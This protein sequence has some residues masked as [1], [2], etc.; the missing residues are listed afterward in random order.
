MPNIKDW[1]KSDVTTFAEL[2]GINV[3]FEGYGFVKEFSINKNTVID[4]SS[5]LHVVL[6]PKY[7]KSE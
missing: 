3:T 7:I 4:K 6:E 1:S 5:T 2:V